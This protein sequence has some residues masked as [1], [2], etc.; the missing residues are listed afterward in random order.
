MW[1]IKYFYDRQYVGDLYPICNNGFG[2]GIERNSVRNIGFSLSLRRLASWCN[3]LNF[4]IRRMFTPLRSSI[5]IVQVITGVEY[6]IQGGF[7]GSTPPFTFGSLSDATV[8]FEYVGWLGMTAGAYLIPPYSYNQPFNLVAKTAIE[9]V[10]ARTLSAGRQWPIT[11]GTSDT[12]AT[13]EGSLEAPKTL[14]D[15]LLERSDNTTGTGNYDV[16]ADPD[17]KI[18]LYTRY[19]LDV[20]DTTTFAYPDKGGKY[21][22]KSLDFEAWQNYISNIFLTGAGNGYASTSG[23]EGAALFSTAQNDDTIDNI[24][25]WQHAVSESDISIQATLDEKA[26][27]YVKDTDKPFVTPSVTIDADRYKLFARELGGELWLGDMVSVDVS[28]WVRPLLPIEL[29][30]VLRINSIDVTVDGL[31][32][33]EAVLGMANG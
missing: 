22:L 28:D 24:G 33:S 15:F 5:K 21:D 32:H 1:K 2:Y 4:D 23:L 25:Y 13:V 12:L 26:T 19:G 8:Q 3:T 6:D 14:K 17:G 18:T 27:S 7:L 9:T 30:V 11:V 31:G 29:P 16:Y 20:S 10:V